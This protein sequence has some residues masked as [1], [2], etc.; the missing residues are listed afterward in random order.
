M[1]FFQLVH[2]A[3]HLFNFR[4]AG[5]VQAVAAAGIVMLA[6]IRRQFV[7]VCGRVRVPE[8]DGQGLLHEQEVPVMDDAHRPPLLVFV[9]VSE[10]L[11]PIV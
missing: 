3:G 10:R 9:F 4:A 5:S 8:V 2:E 7:A 11:K 1:H 6:I